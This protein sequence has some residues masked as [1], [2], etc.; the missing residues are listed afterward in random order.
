MIQFRFDAFNQENVFL[1]LK[2]YEGKR[3]E[4]EVSEEEAPSLPPTSY[5]II[6]SLLC[7]HQHS[8][9]NGSSRADIHKQKIESLSKTT[10]E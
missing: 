2:K 8:E 4:Y 10:F 9:R 3:R 1:A 5:F 7:C 6:Y